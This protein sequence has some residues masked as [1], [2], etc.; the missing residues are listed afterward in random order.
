[1]V[2]SL[3]SAAAGLGAAA[4]TFIVLMILALEG[5]YSVATGTALGLPIV[6]G[7]VV[8]QSVWKKGRV[9]EGGSTP[10]SG[11]ESGD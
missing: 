1:M 2:H 5:I 11:T 6:M 8:G 3:K 10:D 4:L 7:F 9:A